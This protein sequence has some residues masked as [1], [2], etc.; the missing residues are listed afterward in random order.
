MDLYGMKYFGANYGLI[1]T[2]WGFGGVIGPMLAAV[3]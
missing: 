3:L 1:M 2:A